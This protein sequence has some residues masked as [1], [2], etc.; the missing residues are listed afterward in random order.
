MP[1]A[2]GGP[3][4]RRFARPPTDHRRATLK[5]DLEFLSSDE[6][7]GRNTPSPGFD[8]AAEY[9]A[10]RLK[11]AGLEPAGDNGTFLQHYTMRES[12]V[13]T[14]AASIEIGGKR[15]AFGDD[16]VMRSFAGP[17]SGTYAGR[18]RRARLD[19][20]RQGTSIRL[21]ASTSK[22]RS[23]SRT[24]RARCRRASRFR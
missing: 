24:G 13:D 12:A 23:C 4:G 8:T 20:A 2:A 5:R 3:A 18:L 21:R 9:I 15:F 22:A 1:A 16:F 11:K 17:V 7:K 14:A 10:A 6:L 19:G